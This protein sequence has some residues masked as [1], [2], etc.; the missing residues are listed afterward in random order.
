M[1]YVIF[2]E[3]IGSDEERVFFRKLGKV[4]LLISKINKNEVIINKLHTNDRIKAY[5]GFYLGKIDRSELFPTDLK[6]VGVPAIF[7]IEDK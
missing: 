6:R 2:D 7:W 4:N 5:R 3:I 1:V